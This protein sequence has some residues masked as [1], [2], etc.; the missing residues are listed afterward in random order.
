MGIFFFN[1]LLNKTKQKT[2]INLKNSSSRRS[3]NCQKKCWQC[4]EL[5]VLIK[6]V[7][8][9]VSALPA[10]RFAAAAAPAAADAT[11]LKLF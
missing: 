10:F 4:R 1:I 2:K 5:Y 11:L 3:C 8:L 7:D 6:H 9:I